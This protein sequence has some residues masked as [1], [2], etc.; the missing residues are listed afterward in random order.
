MNA[1]DWDAVAARQSPDLTYVDHSPAG[2]GS[3]SLGEAVEVWTS[4]AEMVPDL[5]TLGA[6]V[7]R[8]ED[9]GGLEL[10]RRFGTRTDGGEVSIDH[11]MAYVVV[12]GVTV[13][14]ESFQ[15][16]QLAEALIR[17][18]EMLAEHRED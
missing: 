17:F 13:A 9:D 4:L 1:H 14:V 7:V 10:V 8:S 12:D 5:L 16:E 15:P 11:L 3:I 2:F 6:V 18:D